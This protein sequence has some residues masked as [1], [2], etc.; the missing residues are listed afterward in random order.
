MADA[1]QSSVTLNMPAI[2][3]L[4]LAVMGLPTWL[5]MLVGVSAC[6]ALARLLLFLRSAPELITS[7]RGRDRS[8]AG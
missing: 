8:P 5:A 7:F 4:R 2:W 1:L 3:W 6:A